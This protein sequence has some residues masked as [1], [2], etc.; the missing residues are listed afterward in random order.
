M[1]APGGQLDAGRETSWQITER[2]PFAPRPLTIWVMLVA[3]VLCVAVGFAIPSVWTVLL[4]LLLCLAAVMGMRELGRPELLVLRVGPAGLV[5]GRR[6]LE[7]PWERVTGIE[8]ITYR[9]EPYLRVEV[10][11][12]YKLLPMRS[13]KL[14]GWA[15]HVYSFNGQPI[16][17]SAKGLPASLDEVERELLAHA[18]ERLRGEA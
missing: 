1:Q 14:S 6:S 13:K 16:N 11:A 3:G 2:D 4:G 17:I 9:D 12:P 8:R 7:V 10:T 15:S 18:P 5:I